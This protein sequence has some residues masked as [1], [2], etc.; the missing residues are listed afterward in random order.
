MV[1]NGTGPTVR[2]TAFK[3]KTDPGSGVGS[4]VVQTGSMGS[5]NPSWIGEE[6]EIVPYF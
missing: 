6:G 5:T 3:V 2:S 1:G 4:I